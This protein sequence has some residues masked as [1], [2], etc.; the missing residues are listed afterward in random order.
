MCVCVTCYVCL[1][2]QAESLMQGRGRGFLQVNIKE[3]LRFFRGGILE[4]VIWEKVR[5]SLGVHLYF[6]YLFIWPG[7]GLVL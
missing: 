2:E 4:I 5:H 1:G 7:A 6:I 3:M